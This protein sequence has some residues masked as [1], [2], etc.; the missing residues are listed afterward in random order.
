MGRKEGEIVVVVVV[1]KVEMARFWTPVLHNDRIQTSDAGCGSAAAAATTALPLYFRLWLASERHV[2]AQA[3]K[4]TF[5]F[6][7]IAAA[8]WSSSSFVVGRRA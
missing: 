4:P 5:L 6:M 3:T 8:T 1:V 7:V 2:D